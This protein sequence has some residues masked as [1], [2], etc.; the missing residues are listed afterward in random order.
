MFGKFVTATWNFTKSGHGKGPAD[1][2]GGSIKRQ[3]DRYV[4]HGADIT[5]ANT[6]YMTLYGNTAT[7]IHLI[8]G[9]DIKLLD[10]QLDAS[11]VKSIKGTMKLHQLTWVNTQL[12]SVGP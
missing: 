12:D 6:R 3:A 4:A 10:E 11:K 2:I 8:T 1:G 7:E 5:D 9:D